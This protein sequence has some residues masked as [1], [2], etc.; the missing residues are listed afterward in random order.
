MLRSVG[1]SNR[2]VLEEERPPQYGEFAEAGRV[3]TNG[4]SDGSGDGEGKHPET[5]TVVKNKSI[6]VLGVPVIRST[7]TVT[8]MG[9]DGRPYSYEAIHEHFILPSEPYDFQLR[10]ENSQC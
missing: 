7:Q 5:V 10:G 1:E 6:R 3:C 4:P 2:G 8:V 9:K